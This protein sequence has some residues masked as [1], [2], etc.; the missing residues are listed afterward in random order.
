M[1]ASHFFV[2]HCECNEVERGNPINLLIL[3]I[4]GLL[5]RKATRCAFLICR[6]ALRR[7]SNLRFVNYAMTILFFQHEIKTGMLPASIGTWVLDSKML[8][9]VANGLLVWVEIRDILRN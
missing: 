3:K 4:V 9:L 7:S 6:K 1:G 5:S 2:C 8:V